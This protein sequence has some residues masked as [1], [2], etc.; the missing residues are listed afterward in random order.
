MV[1]NMKL[2][3]YLCALF[4]FLGCKGSSSLKKNIIIPA[5]DY[6]FNWDKIKS[7]NAVLIVNPHNGPGDE[8]TTHYKTITDDLNSSKKTALGYIYSSYGKR[9]IDILK[10]D[11]DRWLE[12]YKIDG[13]FIDE[14]SKHIEDFEYYE[15]IYNYIKSKGD[16]LVF[17]NP[18][19]I[20]D[21]DYFFIAD[22]IVVY[23]GHIEN[24]PTNICTT[25]SDK[26]SI[27]LFGSSR[28]DMLNIINNSKCRYIYVTDTDL[29]NVYNSLPSYF[30]EEIELLY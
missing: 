24:M 6:N 11:I 19:T 21:E 17:L 25:D 2:L 29:P 27:I 15:N 26:S 3:I 18:G 23:E 5:Y 4:A 10:G 9:D 16:Y 13:F 14:A 7:D 28:E 8:V 12:F 30:D 22:N 1:K 20:P